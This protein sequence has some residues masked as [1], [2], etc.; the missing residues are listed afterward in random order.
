MSAREMMTFLHFF[1][2]MVGDLVQPDDEVWLFFLDFLELIDFLLCFEMSHDLISHIQTLIQK[3]HVNYVRLFKDTLKP[4]HHLMT[5]YVSVI[6]QS[7]PPRKY[8]CFPFEKQHKPHKTYARSIT[9][10][11]NI[12][13]SIAKKF[14]L[15]FANSII[16]MS[17]VIN[18]TLKHFLIALITAK[19]TNQV[20]ICFSIQGYIN[21]VERIKVFEIQEII[22]FECSN[23]RPYILCKGVPVKSY[24]RHIASYELDNSMCNEYF[25]FSIEYFSG[26]PI[27]VN[28]LSDGKSYL[29]VKNYY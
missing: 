24:N 21:N 15:E 22:N 28:T 11:K 25:L 29:R 19:T 16:K 4:K 27:N 9:S 14:Q 3:H 1:S 26:P 5:H 10:R 2:Q 7:G 23:L 6:T 17:T 8:W 18:Q 13:V 20:I 12:C